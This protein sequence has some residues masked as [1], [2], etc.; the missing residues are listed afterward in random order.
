[1]I[2]PDFE[3]EGYID[4]KRTPGQMVRTLLSQPKV[5]Q[6]NFWIYFTPVG[7]SRV[8]RN[9]ANPG[10]GSESMTDLS[11]IGSN[12]RTKI[13]REDAKEISPT[14]GSSTIFHYGTSPA[15]KREIPIPNQ[16]PG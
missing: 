16:S 15:E 3:P 1:M 10:D 13:D 4:F 7:S 11:N 9:G 5:G 8:E 12:M 6:P 2:G 14:K